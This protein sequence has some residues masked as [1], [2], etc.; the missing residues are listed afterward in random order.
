MN[1]IEEKTTALICRLVARHYMKR[2]EMS[3]FLHTKFFTLSGLLAAARNELAYRRGSLRVPEIRMVAVELTNTCN[4]HCSVCPVNSTMERTRG[5]MDF[6]MYRRILENNRGIEIVQLCLWGESLMHPGLLDFVRLAVEKGIR[7]YLYTNGTLLNDRLTREILG[8]GLHRIF[9]SLDGFGETYTRIRGYNYGDIEEKIF[10]FLHLRE[11][12][13]RDI[14][15]G[16]AMVACSE[17]RELLASFRERWE[18]IVDEV[19][20]TPHITHEEGTRNTSCRLLWLGYPI[21][22]WDGNVVPCCVD[23]EG[24]LSFGNVKDEPDLGKIWNGEKAVR[25]RREHLEMRFS[26]VCGRCHEFRS[27]GI[28]PRFDQ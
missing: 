26:G 23:Y 1:R 13:N 6:H 20:V 2:P 22:L 14:R 18:G 3:D 19:Q 27:E 17:T 10:R 24:T 28:S 5:F 25:M 11:K 8:S 4:L 15:V 7:A 16:V 9:F 12:E 21:I